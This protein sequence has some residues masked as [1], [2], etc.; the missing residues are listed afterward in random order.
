MNFSSP[1]NIYRLLTVSQKSNYLFFVHLKDNRGCIM[2][3]Y[4]TLDKTV[5]Y[6]V[7]MY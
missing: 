1:S 2:C 7:F 4:V 5:E 3:H 6:R